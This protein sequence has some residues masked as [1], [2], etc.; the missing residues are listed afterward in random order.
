M[1][2]EAALAG[3]GPDA[4][5]VVEWKG[6]KMELEE[7]DWKAQCV[8]PACRSQEDSAPQAFL[9]RQFV[10]ALAL[11]VASL[12]HFSSTLRYKKYVFLDPLAGAVTKTH[13]ALE[14][15][16]EEKL[17][18]A[19]LSITKRGQLDQQV[20]CRCGHAAASC[21]RAVWFPLGEERTCA[22]GGRAGRRM[23]F[24]GLQGVLLSKPISELEV[25]VWA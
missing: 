20:R 3:Q 6:R 24:V 1:S 9:G 18:D 2:V 19:P 14:T 5:L 4:L 12:K 22:G 13:V 16:T 7:G 15:E 8:P 10:L 23:A 21:Y 17:F 25:L 11:E